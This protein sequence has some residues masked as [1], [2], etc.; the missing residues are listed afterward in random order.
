M[1]ACKRGIERIKNITKKRDESPFT[2]RRG[3]PT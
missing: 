3:K 1:T 2:V